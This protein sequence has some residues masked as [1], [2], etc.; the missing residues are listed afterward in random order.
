MARLSKKTHKKK[1]SNEDGDLQA[2]TSS[3]A[4]GKESTGNVDSSVQVRPTLA[5]LLGRL[6]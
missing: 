3:T 4:K 5:T 1:V 6:D 2:G